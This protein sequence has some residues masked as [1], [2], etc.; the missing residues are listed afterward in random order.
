MV[1][2]HQDHYLSPVTSES[3]CQVHLDQKL[4][5]GLEVQLVIVQNQKLRVL[6]NEYLNFS[7]FQVHF[8]MNSR[9]LKCHFLVD[10]EDFH[11]IFHDSTLGL[12]MMVETRGN[13]FSLG[14]RQL[15]LQPE[16]CCAFYFFGGEIET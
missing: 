7:H 2:D 5:Q 6:G 11:F 3:L 8:P 16:I 1:Q 9:I 14:Q 15:L 10:S 13:N 12:A 4:P